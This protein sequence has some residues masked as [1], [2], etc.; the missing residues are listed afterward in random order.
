MLGACVSP[1]FYLPMSIFS[2]KF[3]GNRFSVVLV[4]GVAVDFRC[5]LGFVAVVVVATSKSPLQDHTEE[6]S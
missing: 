1:A 5:S 2:L 3:G 4:M 6:C